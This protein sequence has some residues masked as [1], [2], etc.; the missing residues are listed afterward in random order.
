MPIPPAARFA[1]EPGSRADQLAHMYRAAKE[2]FETAKQRFEDIKA[3]LKA[4]LFNSAAADPRIFDVNDASVLHR[5]VLDHPSVSLTVSAKTSWRLDTP[6]IKTE[7]PDIYAYY[8]KQT[9]AW[10]LRE[11]K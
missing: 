7:R 10:E 2:E 5:I 9:V 8:G 11:G 1:P 4:D 6:R 3:S